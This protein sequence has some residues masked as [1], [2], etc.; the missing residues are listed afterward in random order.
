MIGIDISSSIFNVTKFMKMINFYIL[1]NTF[2]NTP[3]KYLIDLSANC[4]VI[5]VRFNTCK[6]NC[7]GTIK[8]INDTF[9]PKSYNI[10]KNS[11]LLIV[12]GIEKTPRT[13]QFWR[14]F[15][16]YNALHSF[17]NTIVSQS[18]NFLFLVMISLRNFTYEGICKIVSAKGY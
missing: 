18:S 15:V 8:R 11:M 12:H 9:A 1:I 2:S 10:L 14:Q 4:K 16:L 6:P 17:V 7:L 5:L 13:F 3:N